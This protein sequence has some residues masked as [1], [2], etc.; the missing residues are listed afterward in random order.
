VRTSSAQLPIQRQVP[1]A[2][3]LHRKLRRA[4][5]TGGVGGGIVGQREGLKQRLGER[6]GL[7]GADLDTLYCGGRVHDVGK[8]VVP[9][10]TL[11]KSGPLSPDELATIRS[12]VLVGEE[13][14]RPLRGGSGLREIVRHHHERYDG[15]GY[16]DRLAGEE[17]P[18]LARIVAVCDGYEA[19]VSDRPYRRARSSSEAITVLRR[20]A[21]RQWDRE[22]VSVFTELVVPLH[23]GLLRAG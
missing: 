16:P 15:T 7:S 1:L 13:M 18:L 10:A 5:A 12:H 3:P 23:R 2:A 21:G 8:V 6:L 22:L 19:M 14:V 11:Q 20:G 4:G 9:E 17:I